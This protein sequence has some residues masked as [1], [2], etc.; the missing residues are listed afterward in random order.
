MPKK[1]NSPP[2]LERLANTTPTSLVEMAPPSIYDGVTEITIIPKTDK[3]TQTNIRVG[4]EMRWIK[5][6]ATSLVPN[7]GRTSASSTTPL[8]NVGPTRSRAAVRMMT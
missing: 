7:D 3:R 5:Y 8:G 1:L 6:G 2:P 4:Y